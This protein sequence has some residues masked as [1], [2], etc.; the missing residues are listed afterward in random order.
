MKAKKKPTARARRSAR[1]KAAPPLHTPATDAKPGQLV[2]R[3]KFDDGDTADITLEKL[4]QTT[5]RQRKE[6]KRAQEIARMTLAQADDERRIAKGDTTRAA[7]EQQR[8]N[9]GLDER[10]DLVRHI[11]AKEKLRRIHGYLKRTAARFSGL[12]IETVRGIVKKKTR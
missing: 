10:D 2:A 6:L 7:R 11:A 8:K 9:R 3:F 1:A 5:A 12:S 4:I